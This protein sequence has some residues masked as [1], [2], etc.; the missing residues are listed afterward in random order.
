MS[1]TRPH[2]SEAQAGNPPFTELIILLALILGALTLRLDIHRPV[3][4]LAPRGPAMGQ[5]LAAP[6]PVPVEVIEPLL[7][8][9]ACPSTDQ[10]QTAPAP[11]PNPPTSRRSR[12]S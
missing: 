6:V 8:V 5:A 7:R 1:E 2:G 4:A 12:L 11:A 3:T 9:P 10:P